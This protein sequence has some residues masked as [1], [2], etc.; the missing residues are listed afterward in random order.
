[1][2][3]WRVMRMLGVILLITCW[4]LIAWT[5]AV[6]QNMDRNV[7]LIVQGQT[8][9]NLQFNMCLLDRWDYMMAIAEFLFLLWGI[10]L[11][12]AVRTVPSAFHEP[13]Y[14][15]VAVHNELIISAVFHTI[16]FILASRLHPDWILMLFFAHTHLTVTVTLGLLLV[17]K[18]TWTQECAVC[19]HSIQDQ[20]TLALKRFLQSNTNPRDDIA[21][22]AYEDEL[23]MGR[24]G[25]YL[26]S[27]ITSAWSEHSL[28]PDDIRD[29]LK[30]LY[31][32]L[33]VYKR[34][35]MIANNPHLQKKRSS[36]KGLG[37]SIMRR[38][39]EIPETMSR[40][41]DKEIIDHVSARNSV[42]TLRKPQLDSTSGNVKPKEDTFRNRGFSL[43]K[44]HSSYD[45]VREQSEESNSSATNKLEVVTS[46]HSLLDSLIGKK[47]GKKTT[48]KME[49]TST[50]SVPLVCKS[51]SAHNLTVDKKPLHPK[52][53]M[54]QKSLSVIASAKEKTLGLTGK[55]HSLEDSNKHPKTKQKA[56]EVSQIYL[57]ADKDE[58]VD[59]HQQSS[60]SLHDEPRKLHKSGIMKQQGANSLSSINPDTNTSVLKDK[61]DKTE[62]CPWEVDLASTASS[63]TKIQK[64]VSIAPL[65]TKSIHGS[66]VKGKTQT[67]NKVSETHKQISQKSGDNSEVCPWDFQDPQPSEEEKK[68]IVNHSLKSN[69]NLQQPVVK[70]AEVCPWDFEAPES[71]N[72]D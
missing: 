63:E 70:W 52:T 49:A 56:K 21:T 2:T 19:L 57:S 67:K 61:L 40:R 58:T 59:L 13:R 64:H 14:M 72:A 34:K 47:L 24:S 30:K 32:Q 20:W 38:I 9:D 6:C 60:I 53:S 50:E 10:Y 37:R 5:S 36:K 35:K 54:L 71:L 43:K 27:S 33:E 66:H 65:E 7:P 42:S 22:E 51:A 29:E 48:E 17:P 44:S 45:H 15:A 3:S 62:I 69:S 55:T 1:M 18:K 16:R 12:Y 39:T 8:S 4:F 11:C 31:A 28:D 68:Q 46:E 41:D 25:S 23:D 26:N